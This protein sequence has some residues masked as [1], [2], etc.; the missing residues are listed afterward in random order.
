MSTEV[1][2]ALANQEITPGQAKTLLAT[3]KDY[4]SSLAIIYLNQKMSRLL[5]N[6]P[7]CVT[8]EGK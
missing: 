2:I 4:S 1:F 8:I 7:N 3:L 5:E 6:E